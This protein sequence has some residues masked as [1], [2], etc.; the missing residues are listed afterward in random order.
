M[1]R[2][3]RTSLGLIS[4]LSFL[5]FIGVISVIAE[6]F[7]TTECGDCHTINSSWSMSSNST[8]MAY[9]GIPFTLRINASKPSVGGINLYL[10]LQNGWADNDNFN[11]TPA[12]I[13]DNSA[14]DLEPA[15]FL[16]SHDFTFTPLISGNHTIR[17]WAASSA[18]SQF[19]DI[20]I[21]VPEVPDEIPPI[22]DSP[23]DIEYEVSNL[24]H[25]I[26]WTPSD[27]NPSQFIIKVNGIV[28]LSGGW[29]GQPVVINVDYLSPGTYEYTLTVIDIGGNS[30]SDIVMV[31]VTGEITPE[32]T[33]TETTP[34]PTPT[35]NPGTPEE[36][37]AVLEAGTFSLIMLSMLAIVGIL[38][39][40]L[41][42][43]RW[44]S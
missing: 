17:A 1:N 42:L 30:V 23:D 20:S 19:I 5:L 7:Y 28:I 43:D 29:N 3:I 27:D 35:G 39:L 37:D 2:R 4:A 40:L 15:N 16:I 24:G 11:F 21:D 44:R 13:Q 10:S 9:I 33:A 34:I 14:G 8:G 32:P 6:P 22:I 12:S 36:N 25:N 31:I 38:I 41:I 18:A 26:V